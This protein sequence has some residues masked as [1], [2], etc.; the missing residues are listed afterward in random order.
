MRK[1][2]SGVLALDASTIIDLLTLTVRGQLL[3]DALL[4]GLVTAY[5]TELAIIE[6]KYILCRRLGWNEANSRVNKLLN[7]GYLTVEET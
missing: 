4:E 2:L 3:K 5:T 7:S 6:T 1:K